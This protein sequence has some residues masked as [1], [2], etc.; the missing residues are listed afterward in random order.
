MSVDRDAAV[1]GGEARSVS[2]SVSTPSP[3]KI[4][5]PKSKGQLRLV[6]FESLLSPSFKHRDVEEE[7]EKELQTQTVS[8]NCQ[9]AMVAIPEQNLAELNITA[10]QA[11]ASTSTCAETESGKKSFVIST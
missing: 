1:V 11:V 2:G 9:R 6:P 7:K 10:H 5:L 8:R 3:E 4:E